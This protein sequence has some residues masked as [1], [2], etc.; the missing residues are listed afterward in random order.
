LNLDPATAFAL[1][2]PFFS[3]ICPDFDSYLSCCEKT[4]SW[5]YGSGWARPLGPVPAQIFMGPL[6]QLKLITG[7]SL[8]QGPPIFS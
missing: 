2:S 6:D 5:T 1:A 4:L 8:K 7:F 3:D